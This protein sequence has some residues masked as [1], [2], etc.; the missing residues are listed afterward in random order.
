MKRSRHT[1]VALLGA[2]AFGLAA[3][4]ETPATDAASFENLDS[5]LAAATPGGWFT[6]EDCQS[7]FAEAQ[8]LHDE[9]APRYEDAALCEQEHGAGNCQADPAASA[10]GG[11]MGSVFMPL[12]MGYLLGS[13]LGGGR[14][15]AQPIMT[16]PGGGF[17]TPGGTSIGNI[18]GAGKV[19][20]DAF[21]KAPVTKGQPAMSAADV[22]KR[23]GF[24]A[25]GSSRSGGTSLGG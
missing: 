3:C 15:V 20:T 8:A 19:S 11:G 21:T 17:T 2:A 13:M 9:T 4:Q 25:T 5:C 24:G 1:A 14:P 18:G 6:P 12:M 22:S 16:K 23:G 7:T 10:Q